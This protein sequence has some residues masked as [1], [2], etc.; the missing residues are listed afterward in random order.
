MALERELEALGSLHV[1]AAARERG[2]TQ[3]RAQAER[4]V[5]RRRTAGLAVGARRLRVAL[6]GG[7]VIAAVALG[8]V[9]LVNLRDERQV[10]F[11]PSTAVSQ[12]GVATAASTVTIVGSSIA[13]ATTEPAAT[14]STE[15]GAPNSTVVTSSTPAASPTTAATTPT[16]R[17]TT[18]STTAT[19]QPSTTTSRQVMAKEEKE[20][21]ALAVAGYLAQA[22]SSGD[23][24]RAQSL[25]TDEA[26]FGLN[27]LMAAL[28]NPTSHRVSLLG[29][30]SAADVRM[31]LEFVDLRPT[32][33]G[34][35][36]EVTLRFVC[37]VRAY[38]DAA[39]VTAIYAAP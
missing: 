23:R 3:V 27:E 5:E 10:A 20:R 11:I 7:L 25:I 17:G 36:Q 35:A 12:S 21:Q 2:W 26:S 34:D 28:R 6:A 19:T 24:I 1:P 30:S 22:V 4:Q 37:T 38:E 15:A 14:P 33:T 16:T 13:T 29:E 9:S 18:W 32:D 8:V 31:V 39:L